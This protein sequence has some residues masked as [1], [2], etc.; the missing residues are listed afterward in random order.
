M[1]QK[2]SI[3]IPVYNEEGN[4]DRLYEKLIKDLAQITLNYEIFFID[5]GS[6]DSTF[7]KLQ[8]IHLENNKVK[9]IKFRRNFG[10]SI[11]LNTA[12]TKVNGDV[13]ITMD[14]DLQDDS[15][16]I[17][18]FLAKIEAGF[19]MVSGWKFPRNDP[20]AKRLPSRI[21]N[22]LTCK[23]T[24]LKLHDFNCGFKAYKKEVTETISLYGEMHR[25]TPALAAFYGFRIAEI[26]VRHHPRTEGRSKF[27][28]SR[29]F[30]GMFDLITV[31]YLTTYASRPLHVFGIPGFISLFIGVLIGLY[32]IFL[33]II[34]NII[35]GDRPLLLLSVLLIILGLQFISLGLL[36]EMITYREVKRENVN[37][38][39]ETF[40]SD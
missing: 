20:I 22:S 33:R 38:F 26:K 30:K 1:N 8:R 21:F 24:G 36:G 16:E 10:K 2:L 3:I 28:F 23:L 12:F 37:R 18:R 11:A 31:K 15:E 29:I 17:S 25:Y 14:G 27:G 35:L 6:V 5:D 34:E 40:L 7:S 39:I 9:V 19:D 13:I 4:V 32:L